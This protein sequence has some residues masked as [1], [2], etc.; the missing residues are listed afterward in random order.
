MNFEKLT[1]MMKQYI[2][3]KE[4]HQDCILFFRL[5]D[6]YEMFFEDA[7]D[8]SNLLEIVL[9]GKSCGLEEKVPMCGVP[10]HSAE[11]YI[12]K[13]IKN[14][15]KVAICEQI[16]DPKS[17]KNIVGRDVVR[18]ITPSTNF[19]DELNSGNGN[20]FSINLTQSGKVMF[21]FC[22]IISGIVKYGNCNQDEI[23]DIIRKN[24]VCEIIF[25]GEYLNLEEDIKLDF[26]NFLDLNNI[27]LSI[28]PN[29]V[30]EDIINGPIFENIKKISTIDDDIE[31][32]LNLLSYISYTQKYAPTNIYNISS[33]H[34]SGYVK[35]DINTR[36]NLELIENSTTR[37]KKNTLFDVLDYTKTSMGSRKL[38]SW[39][40][41]PLQ[42]VSEI[43]FRF[44]VI[45]S[46]NKEHINRDELIQSLKGIY[47]VDR[48]IAKLT[49]ESI[50]PRDVSHLRKSFKKLPELK[51]VIKKFDSIKIRNL[52][53]DDLSD[54]YLKI[55][56]CIIEDPGS[57]SKGDIVIC[58]GYSK[59]LDEYV[60]LQNNSAKILLD[61]EQEEREKTGIK[62]LKVKYNKVFGYYIE[63]S[64]SNLKE[65]IPPVDYIRKQ[66]LSNGERYINDRLKN[67]EIKILSS[68]HKILV[69]QQEIFTD[70]KK[71]I[72]EDMKRIQE[73]FKKISVI[74]C[75]LSLSLASIKNNYTKPKINTEGI[76][77]ICD[78]RHPIL[79]T[80]IDDYSY[81]PNDTNI[82]SDTPISIITGPNMGGKS[83]YMRQVAL[84]TIMAHIGCFVPA[85]KANINLID[86]V[87]S[88]VGAADDLTQGQSTF[89]VEMDEVSYILKNAT[90]SSLVILDEVGRGTSTYDG[91]SIAYGII[92]YISENIKAATL[93]STHY[94]E[95]TDMEF[96]L[97]NVKNYS[98][99]VEEINDRVLFLRKVVK[100]RAD[101]SYGI[102]V[103]EMAKLP[104]EI[105]E[106]AKNKLNSLEFNSKM[107][108]VVSEEYQQLSLETISNIASE[109]CNDVISIKE[110]IIIDK[111]KMLNI[112]ILTPIEAL[113]ELNKI[114]NSLLSEEE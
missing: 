101:K 92:K 43:E 61:I 34:E 4:K 90:K 2:E 67:I 89:M 37:L 104:K 60:S 68:Q 12:Q 5:G 20:L 95:I 38:K 65:F 15:R 13:L 114:K 40:E 16:E 93:F 6:F 25:F 41:Q 79:E 85:K 102:H 113:L 77:E 91:M 103:A 23:L 44:S 48:I 17:T 39:I 71:E 84:I 14:G 80:I 21:S 22:D 59:E 54:I 47:D 87:Y 10:F 110:K 96:E 36:R 73:T 97:K 100:G 31:S 75:L 72:K 9:T 29:I 50:T 26:R 53:F 81:I 70:L 105:I 106:I 19:S 32:I 35:I 27:L 30:R 112:D 7:V 42:N 46:F 63:I 33:Y 78:G 52:E 99:L 28:N 1:P 69:L 98:V 24:N 82:N 45:E 66:T 8:A 88:R 57:I 58:E 74:D 94:H 111:I 109:K 49:Y 83:T 108:K 11:S 86:A 62:N 76:Y 51:N 56:S 64:N 3:I 107:E 55:S 18:I